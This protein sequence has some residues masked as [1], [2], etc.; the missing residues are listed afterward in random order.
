MTTKDF[1]ESWLKGG[2]KDE[3]DADALGTDIEIDGGTE[4]IVRKIEAMERISD[5]LAVVF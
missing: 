1:G 4:L 3:P 5:S 2:W